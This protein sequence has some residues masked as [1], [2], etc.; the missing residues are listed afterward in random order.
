MK[1][2]EFFGHTAD[3]AVKAYGG[4]LKELFTSSA[5]AMFSILVSKKQNRPETALKEV[6]IKKSEDAP[7]DLLKA[8]LDE[9]LYYFSSEHLILHRI[10]SLDVGDG[11]LEAKVLLETLDKDYFEYGQEIKAVTYHE[12]KVERKRNKWQAH[13]IFDV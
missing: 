9:L 6:V 12:L 7:E 5:L 10:K 11:M 13:I 2:Y 4:S 3:I 8:W 1:R